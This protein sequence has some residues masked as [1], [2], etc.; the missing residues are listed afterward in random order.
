MSMTFMSPL[1]PAALQPGATI[2]IVA[3]AS[4]FQ[5]DELE[6]G[7]GALRNMG[8]GIRLAEG[9]FDVRGFL[10]GEDHRRAAQLIAMFRDPAVDA[11]I[12]ARGGYGCLRILPLLDFDLIRAHAKP[13]VGFSDITALHHAFFMKTGMVTFHGPV[14]CTLGKDADLSRSAL[15]QAL[16][17]QLPQ[18]LAVN[19]RSILPGMA[20]GRLAGGNLTTLCHLLGTPFAPLF[21]GCILFIEDRGEALYRID[22][23]LTQ[24]KLSGCFDGL[25]GII[26][27]SFKDCGAE[28]DICNLVTQL[29]EERDIPIMAGLPAG[30]AES[31]LTLPLGI[32]VRLDADKGELIL[33]ESATTWRG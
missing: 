4:P 22:R 18:A 7:L 23:M 25:A 16:C 1:K 3:P 33:L 14:V 19:L 12:C 30:H 9:L 31:N 29:F 26:L 11:V 20:E 8:F 32:N 15:R 5:R 28:A 24:M 6:Q 17:G 27:G 13:F 21:D 10:A 2:G